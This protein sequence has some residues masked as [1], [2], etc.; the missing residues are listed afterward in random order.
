[1]EEINKS[2]HLTA[3]RIECLMSPGRRWPA[4]VCV[5][6]CLIQLRRRKI[7]FEESQPPRAAL[8]RNS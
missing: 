4:V 3:A 5:G 8:V 2:S 6:K 7:A 1:M